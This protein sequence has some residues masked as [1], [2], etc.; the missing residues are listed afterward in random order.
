VGRWQGSYQC[1]RDEIGFSL[2]IIKNEGNHVDAIFEFF[3]LA[4]TP[5]FPRGSFRMLG[6]Y[7]QADGSIRL[8]SAGWLQRPLG[9]QSHDLEGR[10]VRNGAEINGRIL[11]TGCA[12][13]AL[14]RR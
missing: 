13:F 8:R 7:D 2:D 9:F 4:G 14:A 3:P 12:Q 6:E 10:L 1:Q 5:S 11:T